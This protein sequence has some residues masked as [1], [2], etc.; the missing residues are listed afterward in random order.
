[1]MC[2]FVGRDVRV[3]GGGYMYRIP[4]S[5]LI[6]DLDRDLVCLS[7]GLTDQ[8]RFAREDG[9]ICICQMGVGPC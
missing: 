2:L 8:N 3:V 9:C 5:L 6:R 1:M 4:M 7:L